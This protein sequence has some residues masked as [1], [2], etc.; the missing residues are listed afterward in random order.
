MTRGRVIA[1][2]LYLSAMVALVVFGLAVVA[3]AVL[4]FFHDERVT[5]ED[6]ACFE[7]ELA[8]ERTAELQRAFEAAPDLDPALPPLPP[9]AKLDPPVAKRP[10]RRMTADEAARLGAVPVKPTQP[11]STGGWRDRATPLPKVT[12]SETARLGLVPV[13]PSQDFDPDAYLAAKQA[14]ADAEMAKAI[15]RS[16][17][18]VVPP[19]P[20][21]FKIDEGPPVSDDWERLPTVTIEECHFSIA[22]HPEGRSSR[23]WLNLTGPETALS[24]FAFIPAAV[25]WGLARWVR[26]IFKPV[27]T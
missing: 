24:V 15:S 21:G 8:A 3:Y 2:R 1:H 22:Y 19:P 6:R 5:L 26:W 27:A 16:R 25:L 11:K 20:P 14:Q 4:S 12:A 17:S 18:V 7:R 10:L 9:G 23:A 13:K